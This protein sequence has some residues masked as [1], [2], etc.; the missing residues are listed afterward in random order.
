MNMYDVKVMGVGS[1][2][3]SKVVTNQELYPIIRNFDL[4]KTKDSFIKNNVDIS[5]MNDGDVF[6]AWVQKVC[7]IKTRHWVSGIDDF[8]DYLELEDMAARASELAIADAGIDRE[9]I[10]AIVFTTMT[11]LTIIPSSACT[12]SHFLKLENCAGITTNNACSGF[13]DGFLDAYAKIRAG[14][15]K[16]VLVAS[17]E[18][19]S[20]DLDLTDP[21]TAILFADGAA[22]VI[23]QRSSTPDV[24]GCYSM[25]KY[26]DQHILM[27]AGEKIQMG[28]GPLVQRN[29]VNA[30]HQAATEVC[31]QAKMNFNDFDFIVP[32]QANLRIINE[33]ERKMELSESKMVKSIRDIGNTSCATVPITVDMLVK[34]K[35]PDYKYKKGAKIL[36]TSVGGGYT[37]A[38]GAFIL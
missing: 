35:L 34:N 24:L 13:L 17:S 15:Y 27:H 29:A 23:M 7:G 37:F 26:S 14:I 5:K 25:I 11:S 28:G 32:H 3:P 1:Y 6:D 18:Y 16:T 10:D 9:E 33:L 38:A 2:L 19:L 21:T 31:S 22:A 30:M 4:D 12:L 36:C 20:K 8:S